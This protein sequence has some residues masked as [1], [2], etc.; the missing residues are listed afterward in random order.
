M[1]NPT[2]AAPTRND[3]GA[4]DLSPELLADIKQATWSF[5]QSLVTMARENPENFR[6][7]VARAKRQQ[8]RD[9]AGKRDAIFLARAPAILDLRRFS[10]PGKTTN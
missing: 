7:V 4:E 10:W 8:A 6:A 1:S 3:Y 9:D 5:W 2:D